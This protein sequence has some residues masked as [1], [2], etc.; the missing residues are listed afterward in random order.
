ML[1]P[2]GCLGIFAFA[3]ESYHFAYSEPL[4]FDY[5]THGKLP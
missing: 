2:D 3:F 4:M 1:E 5:I